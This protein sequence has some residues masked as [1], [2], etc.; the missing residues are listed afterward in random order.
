MYTPQIV[1]LVIAERDLSEP[2]IA[3]AKKRAALSAD[4]FEGWIVI[5]LFL[6]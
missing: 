6:A 2:G 4:M 3:K 1:A 5:Q